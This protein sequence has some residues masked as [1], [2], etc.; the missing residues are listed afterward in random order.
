VSRRERR[1][2][3]VNPVFDHE[4]L[5]HRRVFR[6]LGP[7]RA[8][9]WLAG[10]AMAALYLLVVGCIVNDLARH[11]DSEYAA[12]R[13]LANLTGWSLFGVLLAAPG[14][15]AP[16]LVNERLRGSWDLLRLTRLSPRA[17]VLGKY[18]GRMMLPADLLLLTAVPVTI[19]IAALPGK[20]WIRPLCGTVATWGSALIGFSA[21]G[22][23]ASS[24]AH[25]AA[26]AVGLAYGL[27]AVLVLGVPVLEIMLSELLLRHSFDGPILGALTSPLVAWIALVADRHTDLDEA[28]V[29][30]SMFQPLVWGLASIGL[31]AASVRHMTRLSA[32]EPRLLFHRPK[33]PLR[34]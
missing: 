24:R 20:D 29:I 14:V 21:L 18:F 32:D 16:A 25:H 23:W 12:D 26:G 5:S 17:I 28:Y 13:W 30:A 6:K 27:T 31:L 10:L 11:A 1:H 33:E 7:Q 2:G 8:L 34:G 22:L 19:A 4:L 3:V 9:H 15:M